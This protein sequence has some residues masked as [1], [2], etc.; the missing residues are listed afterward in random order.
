[1][2]NYIFIPRSDVP[3]HIL[4][5]CIHFDTYLEMKDVARTEGHEDRSDWSNP[6]RVRTSLKAFYV[7]S[8]LPIFLRE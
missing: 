4:E 5:Y 6:P 1:M 2:S 8:N 7:F 3:N